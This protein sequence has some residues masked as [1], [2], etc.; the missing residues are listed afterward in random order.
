MSSLSQ[1]ISSIALSLGVLAGLSACG[2]SLPTSNDRLSSLSA[3]DISNPVTISDSD[4]AFLDDV[5]SVLDSGDSATSESTSSA[6][7][8]SRWQDLKSRHADLASKFEALKNLSPDQRKAKMAEVG[9][10][11]PE[12]FAGAH[13]LPH[14]APKGPGFAAG[15]RPAGPPPGFDPAKFKAPSAEQLKAFEALKDLKPEERK[16]KSDEIR[17]DHPDWFPTPPA[18]APGFHPGFG[19]RPD[20][21]APGFDPAR[22]KAPAPEALEALKG[23]K[24]LKPEERKAKLDELRKAHPDWF[25]ASG[26]KAPMPRMA[27]WQGHAGRP[28]PE[29]KPAS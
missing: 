17:K 26:A 12:L 2:S 4:R 10:E 7:K 29:A 25:P 24:D 22:F 28:A 3:A 6:D 23:L 21:Q 1:K 9:K 13:P 11:H 14:F 27:P 16:A 8:A 20:G 18:G 15:Q 5:F 19:P